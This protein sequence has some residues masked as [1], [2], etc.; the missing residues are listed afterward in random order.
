MSTF[1][2][3][4][5]LSKK[6]QPYQDK[7]YKDLFPG[8]KITRFEKEDDKILDIKFHIDVELELSNG[9]KLLGQEK[10]LRH[11]FSRFDTFTME[12]YQ[13]KVTKER[14]EFFKIGAQFYLH[15]Y[16]NKNED[17]FE[18]WYMVKVFDFLEW[19]KETPIELLEKQTRSSTSRANFYYI[20][21][22]EIPDYCI[23]KRKLL[24]DLN[25][26][27]IPESRQGKLF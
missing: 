15:S 21:Y 7:I 12:F 18:K 4:L 20:K 3:D 10:A 11:K 2:E 6:A 23:Y 9:A 24:E 22:G 25:A 13:D 17:G 19:L 27:Q 26:K 5:A 16:W 8:V 14:G 1:E